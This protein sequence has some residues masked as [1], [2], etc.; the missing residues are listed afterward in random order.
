MEYK[1]L[2]ILCEG[3][4]EESFVK[5]VLA[6]YLEGFSVYTVPIILGGVS[7]YSKIRAELKRIGKDSSKYLSTM[8]DYYKLPQD[9]PG[10]RDHSQIDIM[11]MAENI[12]H[13]V[14]EDLYQ[15]LNCK[16]FFPNLLLHEY[17]ALLFSDVTAFSGCDRITGFALRQL[18]EI[19]EAYQTPEHINNSEQTAPSKRILNLY[20]SYQKVS[21]GTIIAETIGIEKMMKECPHFRKWI[22][23]LSHL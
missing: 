23:R 19:R 5:K 16:A 8:L 4:S 10:V 11:D 2:N 20:P 1:Y 18:K 13:A 21:D 22:D 12:E 9:T 14:S 7:R 6:P 17:E 15:E 3:P